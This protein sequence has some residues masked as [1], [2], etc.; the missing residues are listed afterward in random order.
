MDEEKTAKKEYAKLAVKRQPFLDMAYD[1]AELTIPFLLPRNSG[2][3]TKGEVLPKSYQS[4]GGRLVNTLSSKLLLSQ[5]PPNSPFFKYQVDD[6]TLQKLEKRRGIVEKALSSMERAVNQEVD[7]RAMRIPLYETL[8]HLIVTGNA[9]LVSDDDNTLKVYHLDQFVLVRDPQGFPIKIIVQE[10]ISD[11]VFEEVFGMSPPQS[12]DG[13]NTKKDGETELYTKC[14][15]DGNTKTY[16]VYQEVNGQTL[17]GTAT[18]PK[19]KFP[20]LALRFNSIDGEDY[21]RGLVE[22]NIGDLRALEGLSKFILE[23][24]AAAA[25]VV[26][27][28]NPNST[29]TAAKLSKVENLG[30]ISGKRDDVQTL[31]VD[32]FADMRMAAQL[33]TNIETRLS[34]AFLLN[35]S[36]QRQAER[37]TA[38]EI[39]FLANELES[40]LGGIYSL[41]SH[42]LQLPL[43][44]NIISRL[45]KQKKLP[46]L[47]PNTVQ[48]VIVTGFEALGRSNDSQ[49]IL[50]MVQSTV[51]AF[52]PPAVGEFV[53]SEA[54]TRIGAGMAIDMEGLVKTQE[55]REQ[56]MQQAQQNQLRQTA[57][58][59]GTGPAVAAAGQLM[60]NNQQN[61]EQQ[62]Q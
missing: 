22:E 49:K 47:P 32:K 60:Q 1:A 48:P 36:V 62:Q 50:Q 35:Q 28:I 53:I 31:Q 4:L 57:L 55:Q 38:E 37:V 12:G 8:R 51:Q 42:E 30:F 19:D 61:Q 13:K 3:N 6:F 44:R 14:V 40:S 39:R 18:F 34:A 58:E 56:E 41:L 5:F 27:L 20:Y 16:T 9:L 17:P 11:E 33:A 25:K 59:K 15:Y 21:G 43:V 45:E 54:I 24:A 2:A 26:F 46:E 7:S 23:A 29:L 10:C 52:G